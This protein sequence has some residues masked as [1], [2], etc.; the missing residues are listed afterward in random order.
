MT[1][2]AQM[3]DAL[4]EYADQLARAGHLDRHN[5][6]EGMDARLT[7]YADALIAQVEAETRAGLVEELDGAY[8]ER[9]RLVAALIRV[10]GYPAEVVMAPDTEGWWIVYVETPAGQ[11]SWHISPDDMDLFRD[12]PV[13]FGTRPSPWDGHD[14]EEKYRRVAALPAPEPSSGAAPVEERVVGGMPE[15]ASFAWHSESHGPDGLCRGCRD[16]IGWHMQQCGC[17]ERPW[18]VPHPSDEA[19]QW[20]SLCRLPHDHVDHDPAP[21][22]AGAGDGRT[23]R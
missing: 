20:A 7:E 22:S 15:G 19:H 8:R 6:R 1:T 3:R 2:A 17:K 23:D 4:L 9:N 5:V 21:R 14:T 16:H 10:G 18:C 11:A 12:W 13:A